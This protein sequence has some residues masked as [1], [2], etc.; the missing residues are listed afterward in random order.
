MSGLV[1]EVSI[2]SD[3]RVSQSGGHAVPPEDLKIGDPEIY[4]ERGEDV[5]F[6]NN[7][8]EN[9]TIIVPIDDSASIFAN[10]FIHLDADKET[11]VTVAADATRGVHPYCVYMEASDTFAEENSTPKMM[12]EPPEDQEAPPPSQT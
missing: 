5:T 2:G 1:L 9:V 12:I 10:R 6:R 4:I 8:G 3:R 11:T 7:S